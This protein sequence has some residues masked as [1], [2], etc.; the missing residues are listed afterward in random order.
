MVP[1]RHNALC[2][3]SEGFCLFRNK[4]REGTSTKSGLGRLQ[5][6]RVAPSGPSPVTG[7]SESNLA[8]SVRNPPPWKDTW[9]LQGTTPCAAVVRVLQGCA[10]RPKPCDGRRTCIV[11]NKNPHYSRTGRCALAI[12]FVPARAWRC[13][14][15]SR[16]S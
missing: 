12:V 13:G 16:L 2:G 11:L 15:T 3:C 8:G 4:K 5:D 1:A 10:F 6:Y 7:V 14:V 9:Y